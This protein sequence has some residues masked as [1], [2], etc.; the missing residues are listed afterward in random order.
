[1]TPMMAITTNSSTNVNPN[2]L[3]RIIALFLIN[4]G[5]KTNRTKSFPARRAE[6]SA[7][8]T[9]LGL[10]VKPNCLFGLGLSA[11]T[12]QAA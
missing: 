2:R 11:P 9:G 1:M 3:G 12:V 6:L 10:T 4:K 7:S 8:G 5:R